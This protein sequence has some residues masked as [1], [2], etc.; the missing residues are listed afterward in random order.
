MSSRLSYQR[1]T[2]AGRHVLSDRVLR[3]SGVA[4][5]IGD[6]T[7]QPVTKI[8]LFGVRLAIFAL[9]IYWLLMFTGTHLTAN[10]LQVADS[11]GPQ[12]SDK[13]KHFGAFFVL[14][15]LMCYVTNSSRLVRRFTLIGFG[16]MAYA[17]LDE[18]TQRFVAG[19]Y[20]DFHDF[21]ADS[22]GLW[23]AIMTYAVAKLL[24]GSWERRLRARFYPNEA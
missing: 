16:G 19:R 11:I 23:A 8:S 10:T 4:Y 6:S 13:V 15:T 22:L 21:V 14:G 24:L 5:T 3:W 1:S 20:P 17:A 7:M 18:Y 12:V 9:G 2:V